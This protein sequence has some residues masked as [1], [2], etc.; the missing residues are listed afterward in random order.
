MRRRSTGKR[1]KCGEQRR[2]H[3]PRV[4]KFGLEPSA[5]GSVHG[6]AAKHCCRQEEF[7][8]PLP[9][10]TVQMGVSEFFLRCIFTENK[11][12]P[13]SVSDPPEPEGPPSPPLPADHV[14]DSGAVLFPGTSPSLLHLFV[15]FKSDSTLAGNTF[16]SDSEMLIMIQWCKEL[17]QNSKLSIFDL[18]NL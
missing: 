1:D 9:L 18:P 13:S 16:S 15:L 11:R 14:L 12:C 3:P 5:Q 4:G 8:G 2:L 10:A 17:G 7:V 6:R